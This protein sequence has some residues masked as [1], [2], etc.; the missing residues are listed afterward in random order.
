MQKSEAGGFKSPRPVETYVVSKGNVVH[1]FNQH[2]G[3]RGRRISEFEASQ[4]YTEKPCLKKTKQTN[5][6]TNKGSPLKIRK[7]EGLEM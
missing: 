2:S 6:Q 4:G 7:R 1:A 3:G 5:K